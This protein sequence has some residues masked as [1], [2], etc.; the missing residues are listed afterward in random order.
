M[1][2]KCFAQPNN[3]FPYKN[4]ILLAG[5]ASLLLSACANITIKSKDPELLSFE[6]FA[7]QV[8]THLLEINPNTYSSNQK[9]L[10]KEVAPDV[11]SLLHKKGMCAGSKEQIQENLKSMNANNTRCLVR[12]ESTDFPSKATSQG[13]IPI[14]VRGTCIKTVK[15]ASKASKFDILYYVGNKTGTKEPMVASIEFKKFD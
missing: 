2:S 6:N 12:I 1:P 8:T 10:T 14:D 15:E 9:A 3:N 11:Y 13:L 7:N 5:L 4:R